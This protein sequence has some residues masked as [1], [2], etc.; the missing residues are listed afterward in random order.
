[1][2]E[3]AKWLV[4]QNGVLVRDP[5]SKEILPPEGAQKDWVGSVGRY[6]RRRAADGSVAVY[7]DKPAQQAQVNKY[8]DKKIM[9]DK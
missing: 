9:E 4:P 2:S 5:M 6:W 1:M 8:Q 3:E 7:D